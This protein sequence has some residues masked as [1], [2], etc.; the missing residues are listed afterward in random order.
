MK[1]YSYIKKIQVKSLEGETD[2]PGKTVKI[3]IPN[4]YANKKY[5]KTAII[6]YYNVNKEYNRRNNYYNFKF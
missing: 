1:I 4:K 2:A 3:S 6:N 5:T